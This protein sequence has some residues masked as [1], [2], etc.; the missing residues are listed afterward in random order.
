MALLYFSV[1]GWDSA[2]TQIS[3]SVFHVAHATSGSD[4]LRAV[5]VLQRV[6]NCLF[7]QSCSVALLSL[8]LHS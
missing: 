5:P 8:Y 1:W 7:P 6:Q 4:Y 2:L 3:C